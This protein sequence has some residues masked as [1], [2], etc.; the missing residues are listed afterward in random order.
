MQKLRRIQPHGLLLLA[1]LPLVASMSVTAAVAESIQFRGFGSL[2]ATYSDSDVL[3]FRRDLSQD[4]RTQHWSIAP[5][6]ILGVQADMQLNDKLKASVQ[7]VFKDRAH[8]AFNDT[9]EWAYLTYDPSND[10]RIRVGR[11]GADISMIGDVGN[12]G[13]AYDWVRPPVEVYGAVPSYHFDGIEITHRSHIAAGYLSTKA[14]YGKSH[15]HFVNAD[16]SSEFELNP[17]WGAA[18]QYEKGSFSFRAAYLNV[19]LSSLEDTGV[20]LLRAALMPYAFLPTIAETMEALEYRSATDNFMSGISYRFDNWSVLAEAS[21][22]DS[23][24][25][26]LPRLFTAYT[27]ITWRFNTVSV[28]SLFAHVRALNATYKVSEDVPEPLRTYSQIAFD[29]SDRRQSLI[30]L[31]ARWDFAENMALKLQWDHYWVAE[32]KASLWDVSVENFVATPNEQV[33]VLTLGVSFVF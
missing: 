17:Y 22:I 33:N 21:Y 15:G 1:S 12:V 30:A 31:G 9:V 2:S 26:M 8:D 23:H 11:I 25:E 7:L 13:Y 4:G 32:N 29:A 14:F 24:E 19:T 16:T 3:G 27:G 6:S 5:D 10:W 18:V 28:Y 20:E